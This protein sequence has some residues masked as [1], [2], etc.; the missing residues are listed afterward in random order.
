MRCDAR[1]RRKEGKEGVKEME[2]AW[3]GGGVKAGMGRGGMRGAHYV[4][5]VRQ[6]THPEMA[7]KVNMV[8]IIQ[9]TIVGVSVCL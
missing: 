4:N 9:D 3:E 2:R 7:Q 1:E 6:K 8:K 5:E